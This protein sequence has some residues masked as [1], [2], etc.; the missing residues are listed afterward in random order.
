MSDWDVRKTKPIGVKV[1]YEVFRV[2]DGGETI[3]RG[4]WKTEKEARDVAERLNNHIEVD[5]RMP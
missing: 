3:F 5:W 1:F 2:A 4:R